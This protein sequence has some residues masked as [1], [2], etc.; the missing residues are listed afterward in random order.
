MRQFWP[1]M[2]LVFTSFLISNVALAIIPIFIGKLIGAASVFSESS[3]HDAWVYVAILAACSSIHTVTWHTSEILYMKLINPVVYRY[4]TEIFRQ[5]LARP[6]PYFVDKFTGKIAS[7]VSTLGKELHEFVDRIMYN[8]AG[9]LVRVAAIV[10]IL[11]SVNVVTGFVFTGGIMVMIL[12]GRHTIRNSVKYEGIHTDVESTK[13]GKIIDAV[14]NFVNIKSFHKERDEYLALAAEQEVVIRAATKSYIWALVFWGSMSLFVR[15]LIWPI[16]III[17]VY[18]YVHHQISLAQLTTLLSTV[19][20]FS[21]YVWEFIWNISQFN[22]K[23]ARMEEAHRYLFGK[24][25]VDTLGYIQPLK[26]TK[27]LRFNKEL[28]LNNL[29]FAYPDQPKQVVLNKVN[30]S[31]EF[32]E[33]IGIVGKSGSGKTTLTKLLLGYYDLTDGSIEVDGKKVDPKDLLEVI[34]YVP[35]DTTLFNRTIAENIAYA[36]DHKV[37]REDLVFMSKQALVDEFVKKIPDTYDAVVGERGVKLSTGQRQR[38]AIARAMLQG[39]PLLILDEATSALDSE[40]EQ[41]V[42]KSLEN[43]WHDRT[44]ISIA[45]RLST[46]RKM[47]RIVVFDQGKIAEVGSIDELLAKKGKFYDLWNTQVNGMIVE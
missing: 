32:G 27:E 7:Y 36:A 11:F 21:D 39:K 15:H 42:Q 12:V 41:L 5:V 35:Q 13:N 30:L 9:A 23:V 38:I 18:F 45:H 24:K 2:V 29:T 33:K 14:G 3:I 22:L 8:Y 17:N 31:I 26:D 20:L 16:T 40:N 6:Y 10:G 34:S 43:L 44:V 47:D 19:L 25:V 46:L 28:L 37:S 1:R 4:E